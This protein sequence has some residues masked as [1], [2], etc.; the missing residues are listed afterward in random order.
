MN[1]LQTNVRRVCRLLL[2]APLLLLAGCHTTEKK[3]PSPLASV[4]ITGNTPGQ[5]QD[6]AIDVFRA[7]GFKERE[8]GPGRVV[9]EKLGGSMNNLAY[10]S[11]LGDDPVW[12]RIKASVVPLGEM[13]YELQC[14]GF[15][16]TDKNGAMEEEKPLSRV[17]HRTYQKVLDDVASRFEHK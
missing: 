3:G 14:F 15:I 8:Q 11:W 6:A 1:G 17:H 5:I 13:K 12:I 10:G 16:V 7:K 2:L 4:V 9:F